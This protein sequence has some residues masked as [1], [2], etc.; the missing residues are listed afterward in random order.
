MNSGPP[1]FDEICSALSTARHRERVLSS[2]SQR[3]AMQEHL[4]ADDLPV[5]AAVE[6]SARFVARALVVW[7]AQPVRVVTEPGLDAKIPFI[8]SVIYITNVFSISNALLG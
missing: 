7:L 5:S 8:D 3:A 4:K 6:S 2:R 1:I